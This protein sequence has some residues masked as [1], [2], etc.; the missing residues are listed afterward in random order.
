M[1][2]K[3]NS[4]DAMEE[5]SVPLVYRRESDH[6]GSR[7]FFR[8]DP[9][10]SSGTLIQI[11]SILVGFGVAYGTYREDQTK[12]KA[13]IEAVKVGA[14]VGIESVKANAERDRADSRAAV[15]EIRTDVKDVKS[16]VSQI[17]KTLAVLEAQGRTTPRQR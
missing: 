14:T 2:D 10:V 17:S 15:N 4:E 13:E 5:T 9:T 12:V 3:P 6:S 16:E 1:S 11:V 8:F 7:R